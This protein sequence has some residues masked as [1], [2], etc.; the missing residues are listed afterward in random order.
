MSAGT[1]QT[2]VG[3]NK[4]FDHKRD[5]PYGLRRPFP[6]RSSGHEVFPSGQGGRAAELLGRSIDKVAFLVEMV[7]QRCVD[8][9]EL[10]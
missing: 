1:W 10:L 5:Q 7:V 9:D 3:G 8:R 2:P 6:A 4:S